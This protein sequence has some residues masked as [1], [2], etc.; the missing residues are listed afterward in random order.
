[1]YCCQSCNTLAW[2]ARQGKKKTVTGAKRPL[3]DTPNAV[4]LE[5]NTKTVGVIALGAALGNLAAQGGTSVV[6]HLMQGNANAHAPQ[7]KIGRMPQGPIQLLAKSDIEQ[8]NDF[9]PADLQAIVSPLERITLPGKGPLAFVRL[10]H[11]GHEL[12]YQAGQQLLLWKKEE[13]KYHAI[14]SARMFAKLARYPAPLAD[15][16]P[17]RAESAG[18]KAIPSP[19]ELT[20]DF[21]RL[22]TDMIAA[23]DLKT[24]Q[25]AEAMEAFTRTLMQGISDFPAA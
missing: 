11:Y 23:S 20:L 18:A 24:Q 22:V 5:L 13:G 2:Q 19:E 4:S 9:L 14:T 16:L 10:R 6:Q 7:P 15:Q 12:Y 1:M 3:E 8:P 25:E 17:I 21:D